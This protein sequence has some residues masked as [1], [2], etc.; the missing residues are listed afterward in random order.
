LVRRLIRL[1]AD[2]IRTAVFVISGQ[3]NDRIGTAL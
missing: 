2:R 1:Y 3:E